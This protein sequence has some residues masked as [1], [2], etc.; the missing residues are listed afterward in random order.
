MIKEGAR[1]DGGGMPGTVGHEW[2]Q[3]VEK[4]LGDAAGVPGG[5]QRLAMG[6]RVR[7]AQW[8]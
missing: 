4:H 1:G 3:E 2:R 7:M 5:C 8:G 6:A